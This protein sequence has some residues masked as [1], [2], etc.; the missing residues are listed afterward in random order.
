MAASMTD[1][2]ESAQRPPFPR[3]W[4]YAAGLL[5][6]GLCTVVAAMLRSH[7]PAENL[8]MIYLVGVVAVAA[9]F[10]RGP[11][12]LASVASVAAFDFVCV[13]PYLSFVVTSL[14]HLITLVVML[15]VALFISAMTSR[16]RIQA[17]AVVERE[18]RV[19][20]EKLRTSLLSAVSHDLRTPLAS[21]SGAASA[22]RAHWDQL[23]Q[24]TRDDLMESIS[25]ET[26]HMNRLLHNILQATRLESGVDL[27]KDWFPLEEVIGA[28]LHRLERQL[29]ARTIRTDVSTSLPLVAMDDVLMEQVVINLVENSLKYTPPDSPVEIIAFHSLLGCIE[30]QVLD[31]GPGFGAGTENRVFEKFFRG[32]TD[33]IRGMGLG[34]AICRAIVEAHGGTIA[35]GNRQGGGAIVR[36]TL[37]VTDPPA[38]I[39]EME[40]NTP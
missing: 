6:I 11:A 38:P 16:I 34:L 3:L 19:Q 5:I 32:R 2:P 25:E 4:E 30:V 40:V 27:Q 21:L 20:T 9:K 23:D 15:A 39:E 14:E 10:H 35:A 36:F 24:R 33:N 22:L 13:E 26:E 31:R 12:M 29:S 8:I 17:A 7:L 1:S 37:P 28:A 18:V